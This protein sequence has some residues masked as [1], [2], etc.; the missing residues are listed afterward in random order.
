[1]YMQT[2]HINKCT[3]H[4]M[5]YDVEALHA[6]APQYL[7]DRLQYWYII[8]LLKRYRGWLPSLLDVRPSWLV[9]VGDRCFAAAGPRL[10][11]SLPDDVQSA[12]SLTTF[13]QK[14]KTHL[15]R[16]SYQF[17]SCVAIVVLE[18]TFT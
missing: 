15:F 6:T 3:V 17:F 13:R 14:L 10:W 12:P 11:N 18:A 7:L 9:T 16:Q 8:D 1:M 2:F 5:A 4:M